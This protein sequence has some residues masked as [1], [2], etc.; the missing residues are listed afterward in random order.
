MSLRAGIR[1]DVPRTDESGVDFI[2]IKVL[3]GGPVRIYKGVSPEC[4]SFSDTY[5]VF[6]NH[7]SGKLSL[8]S[9]PDTEV[10]LYLAWM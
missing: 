4:W 5:M 10:E 9:G 2:Y 3:S 1:T 8:K 6:N 7:S